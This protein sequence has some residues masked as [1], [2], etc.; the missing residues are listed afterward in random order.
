MLILNYK[1]Y[2]H[3]YYGIH[4]FHHDIHA[5][6]DYLL[7]GDAVEVAEDVCAIVHGGQLLRRVHICNE[8]P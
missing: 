4:S 7:G 2:V 6:V 3:I 5:H 8:L 1:Y